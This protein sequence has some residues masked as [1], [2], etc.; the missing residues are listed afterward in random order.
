MNNLIVSRLFIILASLIWGSSFVAQILGMEHIGPITFIFTRY[1]IGTIAVFLLALVLDLKKTHQNN[2]GK[3][4]VILKKEWQ[5]ALPGGIICGLLLFTATFFQQSGLQHTPAGKAAFITAMYII[6]VPI[7]QLFVGK[8]FGTRTWLAI[9]G[10]MIGIYLL[11]ITKDF[12]IAF[13]DLLVLTAT[14]FWALHIL[15]GDKFSKEHDPVKLSTVQFAVTTI[16]SAIMMFVF[17]SPELSGIISS[18]VPAAYAGIMCTAVAYTLQMS[19]QRHLSAVEVS[20]ILSMESVFALAGGILILGESLTTREFIG[21][22]I[23]FSAVTIAQIPDK[24]V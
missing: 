6:I 10:S 19:G 5:A 13:S 8:R 9:A 24:K 21:C 2:G 22:I 14:L 4:Y 17:E 11:S 3:E 20:L 1:T 18:L 23:L 16:A 12:S 15:C 7:L